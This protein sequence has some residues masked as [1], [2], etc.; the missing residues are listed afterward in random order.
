MKV[1][2]YTE[3]YKKVKNSGLGKAINHQMQ[4]LESEGI[5]YTTDLKDDYDVLHINTWWLKSYFVAK[6][7][8]KMGKKVVYHAHSTEEDFRNSFICSNLVS[9]IV[10]WWLIKCY[11]LGDVIVT[12]TP[13]SKKLLEHYKGLENKKIYAISNGID[14]SLFKKDKKAGDM[15]RKT[16]GY[17]K[18]DKVIIGIGL[19][20]K[21]KG[22]IDFVE[23]AKRM[24][25]YKFIWFGYSPLSAATKDVRKAV[26][27]KLD[28]LTFAGYVEQDMIKAALNGCDLYLFP[29]LEETE[30]IPIIEACA[31]GCNAIIRDIKV[32]DE[33]L[34]DG[35][36][37]YKAKDVNE[38]ETKIKKLLT[39]KLKSVTENAHK[40]AEE[41]DIKEVGKQLKK[42]YQG[43]MK[44]NKETKKFQQDQTLKLK[45][46]ATIFTSILLLITLI[47]CKD[48]FN[49]KLNEY[50]KT[51]DGYNIKIYTQTKKK[52]EKTFTEI[53]DIIDT[54]QSYT[55]ADSEVNFIA[56]NED[57]SDKLTI[58]KE[59]YKMLVNL[60]DYYSSFN[61]DIDIYNGKY[62]AMWNEAKETQQIPFIDPN[63]EVTTIKFYSN[64]QIANNHANVYL[65]SIIDGYTIYEIE[66]YLH[67][68]KIDKY[69]IS[70]NAIVATGKHDKKNEKYLI[71]I[72]SPF[73]GN[74]NVLQIVKFT[75]K[76]ISTKGI[77]QNNFNIDGINYSNI[78]SS[79]TK[80]PV[81]NMV[82]VTVIADDA[83]AADLIANYLF[84]IN[85]ETG[86]KYVNDHKNI[87]AI[88]CYYL[89][90][91]QTDCTRSEN[92]D[93]NI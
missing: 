46:W 39:G 4:A 91:G 47:M 12:P 60:D 52:A 76:A 61:G 81:N 48:K 84:T 15:F 69:L 56:Y 75:D 45:M 87:D 34:K 73:E 93:A 49:A 41:R 43:V 74:D 23:L 38:F 20:I 6:K 89:E 72:A 21:R 58:S 2:L 35:K 54:Y 32:F 36:N 8:K 18:T 40:V 5:E 1:L 53:E 63:E 16:Y 26:N 42:V 78:I 68:N 19:Y 90:D 82:S 17:K 64:N 92:F 24:P 3:G 31:V 10:K 59:L 29:T 57:E 55:K 66:K 44:N 85:I 14:L 28:N 71:A 33:W 7:A 62:V 86:I 30:G 88:W 13:Y 65:G 70:K 9:K 50:T 11:S 25:E 67:D 37:V 27:T 80:M 22:I 51:I 83:L 79:K 77:Y